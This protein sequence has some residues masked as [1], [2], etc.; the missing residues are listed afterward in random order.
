MSFVALRE[1]FQRFKIT[2]IVIDLKLT[3]RIPTLEEERARE[4]PGE[5]GR[6]VTLTDLKQ[7]ERGELDIKYWFMNVEASD[8]ISLDRSLPDTRSTEL[9]L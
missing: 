8:Q 7:K 5:N 3:S 9:V 6:G 2:I 4:G 1:R